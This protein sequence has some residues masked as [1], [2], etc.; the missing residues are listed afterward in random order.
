MKKTFQL[1]QDISIWHWLVVFIE[2]EFPPQNILPTFMTKNE[3]MNYI[4]VE[5]AKLVAYWSE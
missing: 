2:R 3:K 4:N 1:T 5:T